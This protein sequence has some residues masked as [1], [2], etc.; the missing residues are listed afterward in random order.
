MHCSGYFF[1]LILSSIVILEELCDAKRMTN[2]EDNEELQETRML[3]ETL[4][5][6]L[7]ERRDSK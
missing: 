7:F 3:F 5:E 6:R 2:E 4:V 1:I